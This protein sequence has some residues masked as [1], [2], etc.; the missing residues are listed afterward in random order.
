MSEDNRQPIPFAAYEMDQA[1]NERNVRRLWIVILV[2]IFALLLT[3][4][5]W[6]VYISQFDTIEY[7]Q[8]EAD[9][10]NINLGSQGGIYNGTEATLADS[11][12]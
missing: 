4:I 5:A 1:R 10:N 6:I 12:K 7:E 2:L 9:V 11:Q 3:N 8:G